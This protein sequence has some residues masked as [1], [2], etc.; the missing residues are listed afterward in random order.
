MKY[1]II[2]IT[3]KDEDLAFITSYFESMKLYLFC[4]RKRWVRVSLV[5]WRK[6]WRSR[7]RDLPAQPD[8]RLTSCCRFY[9]GNRRYPSTHASR[10]CWKWHQESHPNDLWEYVRN[11]Q[12]LCPIA[13]KCGQLNR[14]LSSQR[15][16][17]IG[18]LISRLGG[19]T[20]Y[21]CI[22]LFEHPTFWQYDRSCQWRRGD[23]TCQNP[24]TQ[25]Q[26]YAL[27]VSADTLRE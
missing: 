3:T 23:Q 18:S 17:W 2:I 12:F 21:E 14:R 27:V 15:R 7:R 19:Q 9:L 4:P 25:F 22:G 26:P 11:Y 1:A 8:T 16:S 6:L 13:C 20:E 10:C 24:V 5:D